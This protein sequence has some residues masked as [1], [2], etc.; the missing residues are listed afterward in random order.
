MS[1]ILWHQFNTV[2]MLRQNMRQQAQTPAD[3]KL[4]TA[5]ENMR[6]GACT[7]DDIEF[8]ESRIAGF[9]PENPKL[10]GRDVRTYQSSQLETVRRTP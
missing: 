9:R 3:D 4:R 5:L 6:Y 1:R 10:S 7:D 8:L 2:V